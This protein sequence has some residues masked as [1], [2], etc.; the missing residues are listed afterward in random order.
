MTM[1]NAGEAFRKWQASGER[2]K[3]VRR[4]VGMTSATFA[5]ETG[6]STLNIDLIENLP[7]C[8]KTLLQEPETL[9]SEMKWDELLKRVS[10]QFV[11]SEE[12]LRT[13]AGK[14]P[15]SATRKR[16]RKEDDYEFVVSVPLMIS[17]SV[18]LEGANMIMAISNSRRTRHIV[19]HRI[20]PWLYRTLTD[21]FLLYY[22]GMHTSGR[23]DIAGQTT[24]AMLNVLE[25]HLFFTEGANAMDA[26][27]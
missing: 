20:S 24:E 1:G 18:L 12:W 21:L 26:D 11:I 8:D 2:I 4:S 7:H 15:I 13:G 23:V 9:A 17:R 16:D 6:T 19:Y 25:Q 27:K 14:E 22:Q 10:H 3:R 5:R